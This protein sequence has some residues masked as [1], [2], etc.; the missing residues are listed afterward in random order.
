MTV[1]K[2]SSDIL[3]MVSS[4]SR[5]WQQCTHVGSELIILVT[6]LQDP[7]SRVDGVGEVQTVYGAPY[8]MRI[9]LDPAKLTKLQAHSC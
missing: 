3:L 4:V 6:N 1:N 2:T 9:W 7:I 5:L 8:A